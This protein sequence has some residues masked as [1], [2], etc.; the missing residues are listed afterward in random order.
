MSPGLTHTYPAACASGRIMSAAP[1][2]RALAVAAAHRS[3]P[4]RLDGRSLDAIADAEAPTPR[5][6]AEQSARARI[7][8]PSLPP[9]IDWCLPLLTQAPAIA[10]RHAGSSS[11]GTL[12]RA[13]THA[14]GNSRP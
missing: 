5:T 13:L 6:A 8:A 11:T 3:T 1:A 7:A 12:R 14:A 9:L 10:R 4:I 2:V